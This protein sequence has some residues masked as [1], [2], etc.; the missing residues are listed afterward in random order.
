MKSFQSFI[1][2]DSDFG[3]PVAPNKIVPGE[4]LYWKKGS[5]ASVVKVLSSPVM[6]TPG[7]YVIG[8]GKMIA[9][10]QTIGM[11]K[12]G[13]KFTTDIRLLFPV[14]KLN[15]VQDY[16]RNLKTVKS[17]RS[18]TEKQERMDQAAATYSAM[19][20]WAQGIADGEAERQGLMT[21]HKLIHLGFAD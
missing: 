12:D 15:I 5:Q 14:T 21:V 3:S 13:E 18:S 16:L 17:A 1:K 7:Q 4:E 9:D 6:K 20:T 11:A 10:V 19:R 8:S 2:E